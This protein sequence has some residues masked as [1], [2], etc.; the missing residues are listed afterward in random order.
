MVAPILLVLHELGAPTWAVAAAPVTLLFGIAPIV[1]HMIGRDYRNVPANAVLALE[2]DP[3]YRRLM[4]CI[5]PCYAFGVVTAAAAA[6]TV[7]MSVAMGDL[8]N[9]D[10]I[11]S[12]A[13]RPRSA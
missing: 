4:H 9:R 8:Y 10:R 3:Y 6:T 7:G 13:T 12:L 5:V 1:D 2:A 11:R